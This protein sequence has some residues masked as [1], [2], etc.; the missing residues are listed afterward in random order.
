[1]KRLILFIS[2]LLLSFV[3]VHARTYQLG[4]PD[5]RLQMTVLV[6][7]GIEWSL[8]VAGA[9]VL[10][11]NSISLDLG[12]AV[13]GVS[14]KVQKVSRGSVSEDIDAPFYRQSSFNAKYN[15]LTLKMKGGWTLEFRAY[16][17]GVA[18]RF[19]TSMSGSRKVL[20]ECVEF[21]FTR[22]FSML[23]PY[24]RTSAKD[25]YRTSFESQYDSVKAGDVRS[26]AE[27]LAF[28]PVYVDL[29]EAGRL[30]LT[31]ADLFDYPGAFL[32][33]TDKGFK[34]EFPPYPGNVQVQ[35][36]VYLDYLNEVEGSRSYPWRVVAYGRD[37]TFLPVNNM[38]Y[39]LASPNRIGDTSWIKPGQSSWDWWNA[40]R[41]HGVDFK[42]GINTETYLYDID[43]AAKYGLQ[44][45]LIDDGWYKNKNIFTPI[46]AID[47]RRICEYASQKGVGVLL[48]VSKGVLGL[49]PDKAFEHYSKMGVSG[50]KVD[51]FDSQEAA[52]VHRITMYAEKAAKYHLVLDFHGIYKPTGLSR[53][54]PN[55]LN[56]EGVAGLENL[57]WS[58]E[59]DFDMPRYD[60]TIPYIRQAA[61]QMDYT[62][63]ALR[64]AAKGDFRAVNNRPMSQGTRAHQLACYVV[65]DSPLTM[66]CDSPSDYLLE[67]ETTRFIASIPTVF[68]NTRILSGKAGE[69]IVSLRE[70]DGVYYLGGMTSWEPRTLSIPMNFL[71]EGQWE[72]TLFADGANAGSVGTDYRI[73]SASVNASSS[74]EATLAPGG[75]FV[76]I[77]KKLRK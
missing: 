9:P 19:V 16:D 22:P 50:F 48:W 51:F 77:V 46:D 1:M 44:Y 67:D 61:G 41:R 68:D 2:A 45:I 38:V 54:Y 49:K 64:N 32:A 5:G 13:L 69:W 58:S 8:S 62:P 34:A 71:P 72:C 36:A 6:E 26:A 56:F 66:L 57:K 12:S 52:M 25:P 55:V 59:A 23:V 35:D 29:G 28:M 75:G 37:D 76:M 4:S 39:A 43:F 21:N 70:K 20:G 60:V 53:T 47:I 10:E 3:F 30:L 31:E 17:E 42:A 33:T 40:F 27:R 65:F 24:A 63:G 7:G 14:S 11:N 74:V 73:S 15:Y 18:Y